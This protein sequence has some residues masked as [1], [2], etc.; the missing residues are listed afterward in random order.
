MLLEDGDV[1]FVPR[2]W[3]GNLLEF[4]AWFLRGYDQLTD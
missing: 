2:D 1:V 4:Y 3:I